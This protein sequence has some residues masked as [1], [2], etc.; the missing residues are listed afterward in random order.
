[1]RVMISGS[2]GNHNWTLEGRDICAAD[3]DARINLTA[4]AS[5]AIFLMAKKWK[6]F[7]GMKNES[8]GEG[9]L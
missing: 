3:G 9:G 2:A 7:A 6:K 8:K 5:S 4:L 1:M